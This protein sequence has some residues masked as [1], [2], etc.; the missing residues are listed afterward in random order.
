MPVKDVSE[1]QLF[2]VK[3]YVYTAG[4]IA[5]CTDLMPVCYVLENQLQRRSYMLQLRL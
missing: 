4:L 1:M 3:A 2:V 5:I